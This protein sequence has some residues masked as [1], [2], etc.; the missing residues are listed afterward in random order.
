MSLIHS[1]IDIRLYC[2]HYLAACE[3]L[4]SIHL[5]YTHTRIL[6]G[7]YLEIESSE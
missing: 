7:T 4:C 2:L 6:Q 1:P 5:V 3:Q